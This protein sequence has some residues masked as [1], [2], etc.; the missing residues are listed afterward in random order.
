MDNIKEIGEND[1]RKINYQILKNRG[2]L[3]RKRKKID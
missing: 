2:G 1:S 3:F